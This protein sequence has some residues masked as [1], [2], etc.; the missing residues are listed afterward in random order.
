MIKHV[1]VMTWSAEATAG[2]KEEAMAALKTLPP[3]M[4][5]LS[6]YSCGQDAGV[7]DGNADFAIVAEFDDAD[8]YVAYRDHPVHQ[9][10]IKRLIVPIATQRRA[11]QFEF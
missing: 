9:D 3:L 11:V 8:S 6:S 2:Q 1:V 5:G 10:I 7:T 4:K